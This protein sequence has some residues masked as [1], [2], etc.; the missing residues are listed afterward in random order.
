MALKQVYYTSSSVGL[1]G[2]TG[3]QINAASPGLENEIL[4]R[5]E[6]YSGY[7]PPSYLAYANDVTRADFPV[8]LSYYQVM[9]GGCVVA[10]S[11]Y[12]GASSTNTRGGNFF[13]HALVSAAGSAGLNG[14][15]PI[16]LWGAALWSDTAAPTTSLPDL[17]SSAL[18]GQ[19][20]VTNAA[21]FVRQR[22]ERGALIEPLMN[23]VLDG[24]RSR[25]RVV[26]VG[27][28]VEC[29]GW[30]AT[31]TLALPEAI[32][33]EI[34]FTTY[35]RDVDQLDHLI[36]GVDPQDHRSWSPQQLQFDLYVF[37]PAAGVQSPVSA[38]SLFARF[39]AEAYRK[40]AIAQITAFKRFCAQLRQTVSVETLDDVLLLYQLGADE[41][42]AP[43]DL[44][45]TGRFMTT[46]LDEAPAL[47]APALARLWASRTEDEAISGTIWDLY[48]AASRK[49]SDSARQVVQW[50]TSWL[51]ERWIGPANASQIEQLA[52]A[53]SKTPLPREQ[54]LQ[55]APALVRE[56][57]ATTDV[58]RITALL[59]LAEELRISGRLGSVRPEALELIAAQAPTDPIVHQIFARAIAREDRDAADVLF[60]A[61]ARSAHDPADLQR[62]T[63]LLADEL[64]RRELEQRC[65][66]HAFLPLFLALHT[67]HRLEGISRP[68]VLRETIQELIASFPEY[69]QRAQGPELA[70]LLETVSITRMFAGPALSSMEIQALLR[71]FT[72][73]FLIS[74][75]LHA[76]MIQGLLSAPQL[77]SQ[78]FGDLMDRV[79]A[80]EELRRARGSLSAA[81]AALGRALQDIRQ[82]WWLP[83]IDEKLG[84]LAATV[85]DLL[86][87]IPEQYVDIRIQILSLSF[88]RALHPPLNRTFLGAL[89]AEAA[90]RETELCSALKARLEMTPQHQITSDWFVALFETLVAQRRRD[91]AS[92]LDA[93]SETLWQLWD[94]LP[95][96]EKQAVDHRLKR[97]PEMTASW[98]EWQRQNGW[99]ASLKGRFFRQP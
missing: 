46:Q 37:D 14:F 77:G 64:V 25:R 85:G 58:A 36:C 32:A 66:A 96:H 95:K 33:Y 82:R 16:Q 57:R 76:R 65:R 69:Q 56:L 70:H 47:L 1:R 12:L 39:A 18:Q 31:L 71:D 2:G 38:E 6:R 61:L 91:G 23:A 75:S 78:T 97:R 5:I 88:W 40:Q 89:I 13:T 44:L 55:V 30:V 87:V 26:I 98:Q 90:P 20:Q 73:E 15:M 42:A 93:F 60:Q 81:D 48:L 79:I 53:L 45:R 3:F 84:N 9:D 4:D 41:Q 43:T 52:E 72:D 21:A 62:W 59:A 63:P 34:S 29:A 51:A 68:Q 94:K 92:M 99:W 22:P 67:P 10:N 83:L 8:A 49:T 11:V 7:Q 86:H 27:P 24:L 74:T 28:A 54:A 17:P 80:N 35:I 50:V 19:V